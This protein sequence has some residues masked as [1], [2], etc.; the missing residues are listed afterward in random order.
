M[1]VKVKVGE[2]VKWFDPVGQPHDALVTRVHGPE[3]FPSINVVVVNCDPD[4]TDTYGQKIQRET[5]VVHK[6]NQ[7]ANGRYWMYVSQ[8]I[9][10]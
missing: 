5:S 7:H 3:E 9:S 6:T 1:K 10:E 4:Q 8:H 2:N